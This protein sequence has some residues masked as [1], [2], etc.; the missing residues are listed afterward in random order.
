MTVLELA[1]NIIKLTGSS[2]RIVHAASRQVMFGTQ[3]PMS[4]KSQTGGKER[5][6]YR[7]D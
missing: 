1:E 5:S 3:K 7:R 6:S 4:Q 2:S